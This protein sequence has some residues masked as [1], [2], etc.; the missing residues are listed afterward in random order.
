MDALFIPVAQAVGASLDQIK[1]PILSLQLPAKLTVT[2]PLT[3]HIMPTNRLSAGQ[4][5]HPRTILHAGVQASF[6]H[7]CDPFFLL[8]HS[9]TRGRI[10]A[11][12]G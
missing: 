5:I 10:L 1:V 6:Q 4:P 2:Y 8:A 9:E 12:V 11:V 3:A 7:I